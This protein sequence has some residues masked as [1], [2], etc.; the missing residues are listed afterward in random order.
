MAKINKITLIEPEAPG[1]HV[2]SQFKMP[3][4]GLP[5]LGAILKK[6]GY[7]V[8]LHLGKLSEK[9]FH[10]FSGNDLIGIS[11]TTSTAPEAYRIADRFRQAGKK[12]V[13]G[14]V[15][16]TFVTDESLQH[17]DFVVRGEAERTFPELI[18]RIQ[19][20]ELP[21]DLCGV[22]FIDRG[23][24]VHNPDAPLIDDLDSLPFPD[25]TLFD[26]KMKLFNAPIQTSRGCPYPCN[27]CNVTQMFGRKVRYRS[28]EHVLDE[29]A[30]LPKDELFYY[31]DNF[32]S[33]PKY[34]K[35]LCEGI[36]KRG[37]KPKYS[38][39]QVRIEVTRDPE[40]MDLMAQ[41]GTDL[42]YVGFESVV[43]ETLREYKKQQT[44]EEIAQAVEIF[45]RFKMRVHGM[46]VIGADHDS[47]Q[48]AVRTLQ[49][50]E[51]HGI[52]TIQLMM[53]TPIPGT[54]L[55]RQL[56]EKGR[57]V[58]D[59]WSLYDGQ[60][61][62]YM[63]AKML[64]EELQ[65]TTFSAMGKFYSLRR[66][67]TWVA[68]RDFY[69]ASRRFMGWY[70]IKRWKWDNRDWSSLLHKH[71]VK[72]YRKNLSNQLKELQ[73]QLDE[74]LK[75]LQSRLPEVGFRFEDLL[76]KGEK[77]LSD[78]NRTLRDLKPSLDIDLAALDNKARE[79]TQAVTKIQ[80]EVIAIESALRSHTVKS[81]SV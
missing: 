11:T 22:S 51:K 27:F 16:A 14:G 76:A 65:K 1:F 17:A 57:I 38:S 13:I 68:K 78:I 7:E 40:L 39:A 12:V 73:K 49:F 81:A 5:L 63:P 80:E 69:S 28:V 36:L 77:M 6:R 34:T 70:L 15:H 67:L 33:N 54:E 41:A 64:P 29:M 79:L 21:R 55:Y 60:H 20:E 53:L 26:S 35:Q 58:S 52:D 61:A 45:R 4:L 31:D 48:T 8:N 72:T 50:A 74:L 18:S 75:K 43:P 3:R 42:V 23:E 62:V 44:V 66:G 25:Y 2:F 24:T 71:T 59:D 46:F 19:S 32:C 30:Q 10:S 47:K 9:D 56:V 37:I